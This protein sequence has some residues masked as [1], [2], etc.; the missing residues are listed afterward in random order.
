MT[1]RVDRSTIWQDVERFPGAELV[2]AQWLFGRIL[3]KNVRYRESLA[4]QWALR[5]GVRIFQILPNGRFGLETGA[6]YTSGE[7]RS[8]DSC[9][10]CNLCLYRVHAR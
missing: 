1:R 9:H 5:S 2:F 6:A 7:F 8:K 10:M 3:E 4:N